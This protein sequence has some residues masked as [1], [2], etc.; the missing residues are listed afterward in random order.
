M[1]ALRTGPL[2]PVD[3]PNPIAVVPAERGVVQGD[4]ILKAEVPP[5]ALPPH[6]MENGFSRGVVVTAE[7]SASSEA[8]PYSFAVASDR[9]EGVVLWIKRPA[10][11]ASKPL[12]V[13]L[14][15]ESDGHQPGERCRIKLEDTGRAKS[16]PLLPGSWA[17][18]FAHHLRDYL[19][20]SSGGPWFHFA[21][22]RVGAVVSTGHCPG[23]R[24]PT[25]PARTSSPF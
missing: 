25:D 10:A 16:N 7:R 6:L 3:H 21:A 2:A 11:D 19:S 14:F 17:Q 9:S 13:D 20:F 15:F 4:E 18:A 1:P 8:R 22:D 12:G 24:D 23:R 5:S